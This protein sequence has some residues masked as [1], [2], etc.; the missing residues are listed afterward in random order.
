MLEHMAVQAKVW[1]A[2]ADTPS[3]NPFSY[4]RLEARPG[5]RWIRADPFAHYKPATRKRQPEPG[6]HA[7]FLTL[8]ELSTSNRPL[9]LN[10]VD[11]FASTYGLL[12]LFHLEYFPPLLPPGKV[13]IAPEAVIEDDGCLRLV[14]S[15][16]ERLE[17]LSGMVNAHL[18]SHWYPFAD[19]DTPLPPDRYPFT[20]EQYGAVAMPEEVSL[21]R[22]DFLRSQ[23]EFVPAASDPVP[24]T[25]ARKDYDAVLVLDP[26]NVFATGVSVL[27][28]KESTLSW[29]QALADF[30]APPYT[31][32]RLPSLIPSV[33]DEMRMAG[34]TDAS[35]VGEDGQPTK[36]WRCNS[37]LGS[38]YLMLYLDLM[39]NADLR[40][41]ALHDCMEYYR[42]GAQRSK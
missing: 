8:K 35:G 40:Q 16:E 39:G 26:T 9:F 32:D 24:W 14:E 38:L 36:D 4:R 7:H 29:A 11:A 15:S 30:P 2:H 6:P 34:V 5:A 22:K 17:L 3:R 23:E 19:K 27:T 13:Y 25:E 1:K 12:G 20:E 21:V 42:P 41:C 37:V 33:V 28:R 31:E 18:P 10:A